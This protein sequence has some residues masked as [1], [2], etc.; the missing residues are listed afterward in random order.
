MRPRPT[1]RRAPDPARR[2]ALRS[3]VG[4]VVRAVAAVRAQH[5]ALRT[6]KAGEGF[7]VGDF[8]LDW[9][10]QVAVCPAGHESTSWTVDHNQGREVVHIRFSI[11]DCRPCPLKA[12]CTRATRRVLTPRRR[13]AYAAL[14]AARARETTTDFTALYRRRAGIEGT[15][16][17]GVRAMHLRQARYVGLAKTH[18]Q[19][20]LTAAALNLVRLAAW[21]RGTP[22][23]RTRQSAYARLMTAA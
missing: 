1:L 2:R 17:Q 16:S 20:V 12:R 9:A 8:T 3:R 6:A 5:P 21:L 4:R 18:L 10:R 7:A 19:H 23:A 22:L 15:I 13:D 14:A 11:T